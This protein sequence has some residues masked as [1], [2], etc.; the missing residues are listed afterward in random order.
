MKTKIIL[1]LFAITLVAVID[2]NKSF[3]QSTDWSTLGNDNINPSTNFLG[4]KSNFG[5]AFRT[6]NVERMRITNTG[7]VGI[8]TTT[9]ITALEVAKPNPIVRISST[10][11]GNLS[12]ALQFK[13]AG[14]DTTKMDWEIK[15]TS[16]GLNIGYSSNDFATPSVGSIVIN[17]HAITPSI[18]CFFSFGSTEYKWKDLWVCEAHV[19]GK[20]TAKEIEVK[21]GWCDYVF[22]KSYKL[23]PL[24]EVADFI[25]E[26]KHLPN[27]PSA[28]KVENEGLEIG[29]ITKRMMEKIEELTLYAIDMNAR[30]KSFEQEIADLKAGSATGKTAK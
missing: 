11:S 5:L 20:L 26:N 25:Q 8:G 30:M 21:T 12:S 18:A 27:I 22:D 24:E 14:T 28:S 1:V 6:N 15:A 10:G 19:C 2:E 9:P 7:L 13:L 23:R 16:S 29:D 17:S 3:A 4:T